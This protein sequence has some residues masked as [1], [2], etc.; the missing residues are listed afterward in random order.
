MT[1]FD[2]DKG[3]EGLWQAEVTQSKV[4]GEVVPPWTIPNLNLRLSQQAFTVSSPSLINLKALTDSDRLS[5][6]GTCLEFN[7][8]LN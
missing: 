6:T 3:C 5:W 1:V 8:A 7:C 2:E 4:R